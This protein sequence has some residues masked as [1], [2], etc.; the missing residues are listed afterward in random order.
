MLSQI[1]KEDIID[2]VG[3]TFLEVCLKLLKALFE[4]TGGRQLEI[5]FAFVADVSADLV[6]LS[7]GPLNT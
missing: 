1:L 7:V 2:R 6:V 4:V 5:E 3:I